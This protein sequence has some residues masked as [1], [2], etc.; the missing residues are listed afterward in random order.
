MFHAQPFE[1]MHKINRHTAIVG[2]RAKREFVVHLNHVSSYTLAA[3]TAHLVYMEVVQDGSKP[4]RHALRLLKAFRSRQ[5][6]LDAILHQIIGGIGAANE[7]GSI[8]A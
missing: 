8:A 5:G 2:R 6:A 4:T 1:G 7:R 3:P